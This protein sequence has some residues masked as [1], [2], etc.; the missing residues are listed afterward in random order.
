MNAHN[1]RAEWPTPRQQ[2]TRPATWVK[3]AAP[4][5]AAH[6][7]PDRWRCRCRSGADDR[8]GD[9]TSA[10]IG[11]GVCDIR[12]RPP[13]VRPLRRPPNPE[14]GF[15]APFRMARSPRSAAQ[16]CR[17]GAFSQMGVACGLLGRALR[18]V[19]AG[20]AAGVPW[21]GRRLPRLGR[22]PAVGRWHRPAACAGA[23][24][25]AQSD[26]AAG[27]APPGAANMD[28]HEAPPG[29]HHGPAGN[30]AHTLAPVTAVLAGHARRKRPGPAARSRPPRPGGRRA[31]GR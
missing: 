13:S 5:T 20:V 12:G 26:G 19:S 2:M 8:V 15:R 17:C 9:Q 1:N 23:T 30:P 18:S 27:R 25:K 22:H 29:E 16:N 3:R 21:P 24:V 10:Q 14:R 7:E 11:M 31:T 6:C 28:Q 4:S